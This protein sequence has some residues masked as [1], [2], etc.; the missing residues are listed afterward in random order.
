MRNLLDVRLRERTGTAPIVQARPK[1]PGEFVKKAIRK[2]YG[3]P[4]T[5]MTDKA[6]ARVIVPFLDEVKEVEEIIAEMFQVIERHDFMTEMEP[7]RL[8]Y[9]GIH[10]LVTPLREHLSGSEVDLEGTIC[11]IQIHTMA[12]E[13]WA[14]VS[15][16]FLYKPSMGNPSRAVQRRVN[17][18]VSLVEL[19]DEE[20]RRSRQ[21]LMESEEG[22]I[23]QLLDILEKEYWRLSESPFD[24]ELSLWILR[25]VV[26]AYQPS[27]IGRFRSLIGEYVDSE[28]TRLQKLLAVDPFTSTLASQ[29]EAIAIAERLDNAK[30]KLR[31]VWLRSLPEG[32]LD[33]LAAEWGRPL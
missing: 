8:G 2:A 24:P 19:F 15:H 28:R 20:V 26:E 29:P 32:L 5:Q 14:A 25:A 4:M 9:L 16:P 22:A 21:E 31:A 13:A 18:L 33:D 30:E 23:A 7:D 12:Q 3:D 10:Y 11:E 6:G 17:R 1:D 27:D